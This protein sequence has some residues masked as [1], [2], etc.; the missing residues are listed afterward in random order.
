MKET[1]SKEEIR[2]FHQLADMIKDDP[3]LK[4]HY[5]QSFKFDDYELPDGTVI[6]VDATATKSVPEFD[7]QMKDGKMVKAIRRIRN[8]LADEE[9]SFDPTAPG[10][11]W[12]SAKKSYWMGTG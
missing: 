3:D 4:P 12:Q 2:R 6:K 9:G 10:K 11:L 5:Q 8:F 7:F 1:L